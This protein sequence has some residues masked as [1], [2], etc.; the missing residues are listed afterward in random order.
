MGLQEYCEKERGA[1]KIE[2]K[3]FRFIKIKKA[4]IETAFSFSLIGY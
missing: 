3:D 2:V 1:R 4:V